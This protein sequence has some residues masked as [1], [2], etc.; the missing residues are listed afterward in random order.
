MLLFVTT[1]LLYI[2]RSRTVTEQQTLG[3]NGYNCHY[4][5]LASPVNKAVEAISL[6]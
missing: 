6:L 1:H 3:T 4:V 5:V 2:L